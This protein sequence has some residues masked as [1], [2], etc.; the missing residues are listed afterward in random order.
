ML[1]GKQTLSTYV[2]GDAS[3][4]IPVLLNI[5]RSFQPSPY[6]ENRRSSNHSEQPLVPTWYRCE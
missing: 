6:Q 4:H 2:K 3:G 5:S 1:A